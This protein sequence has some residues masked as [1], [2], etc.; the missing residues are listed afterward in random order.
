MVNGRRRAT[1]ALLSF[2]RRDQMKARTTERQFDTHHFVSNFLLTLILSGRIFFSI[3][4]IS[5]D[6]TDRQ[7]KDLR[8]C[9][10]RI[11]HLNRRQVSST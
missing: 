5:L 1:D 4:N 11:V 8:L 2:K 7:T 3:A 9:L 6:Q 10:L